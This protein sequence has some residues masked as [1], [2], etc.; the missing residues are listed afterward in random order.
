MSE[1]RMTSISKCYTNRIHEECKIFYFELEMNLGPT[2]G[3]RYRVTWNC[4]QWRA[5]LC[6]V[7][8]TFYLPQQRSF[9]IVTDVL[10]I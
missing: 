9:M 3:L 6:Y 1:F 5:M 4:M 10:T 7:K 2:A 8:F